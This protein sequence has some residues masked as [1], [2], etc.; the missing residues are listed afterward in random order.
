MTNNNLSYHELVHLVP[1]NTTA[2][3]WLER[4]R[5]P[6]PDDIRCPACGS[7]SIIHVKSRRPMP[8]RC[9]PCRYRFS[10]RK[11][12]VMEGTNVG[13]QKWILAAYL[14]VTHPKGIAATRLA[15]ILK[16][17]QPCAWFLEQR[18]R[19]GF[20]NTIGE[21]IT[22]LDDDKFE[23]TVE[24]DEAM[25]GGRWRNMH[26]DRKQR[27]GSWAEQKTYVVGMKNRETGQVT[28]KVVPD[29]TE[30]TLKGYIR[31]RTKEGTHTFTDDHGGYQGLPLPLH[32]TVGHNK[33]Q[34]V[35]GE[36]HINGMENLWSLAKRSY[37]G[38]F[39]RWS[40]KYVQAYI[41]EL[42][43]KQNLRS[44]PNIDKMMIVLQGLFGK[45]L[46]RKDLVNGHGSFPVDEKSKAPV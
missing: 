21:P 9:R 44:L 15:E 27:Y 34:Y 7:D 43:G 26:Y 12:S 1:D 41:N 8:F 10:V 39:H 13:M 30:A 24:V 23:G 29:R 18:L 40:P 38:V 20:T 36:T 5:W 16:V 25:F 37:S 22:I 46:R 45:R 42:V 3:K 11:N 14:V 17:S 4:L 19:E 35:D 33:W 31:E 32:K 2:E 28:A 6:S